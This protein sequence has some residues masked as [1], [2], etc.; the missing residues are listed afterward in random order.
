MSGSRGQGSGGSQRSRQGSRA[1]PLDKG[2]DRRS[3]KKEGNTLL[4]HL[5]AVW[6]SPTHVR[7][8]PCRDMPRYAVHK[9]IINN[10]LTWAQGW[11]LLPISRTQFPKLAGETKYLGT[12]ILQHGLAC[13][14]SIAT[15]SLGFG[16]SRASGDVISSMI[17]GSTR[18]APSH[19]HGD[20]EGPTVDSSC[21]SSGIDGAFEGVYTQDIVSTHVPGKT[22]Y[23]QY[24]LHRL[25]PRAF[26]F[27]CRFSQSAES[28]K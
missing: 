1:G 12:V 7:A 16:E 5:E 24:K 18:D 9:E 22:T 17:R 6:K 2:R 27:N 28:R 21:F 13:L 23:L 11:A 19:S 26:W 8:F 10:S 20:L 25:L 4:Q 3:W 15:A 14:R